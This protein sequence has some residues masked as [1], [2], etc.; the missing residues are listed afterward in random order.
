[1]TEPEENKLMAYSALVA[2]VIVLVLV[3]VFLFTYKLLFT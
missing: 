2:L 1:M 3:A